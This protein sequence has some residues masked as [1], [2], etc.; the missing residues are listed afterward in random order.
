MKTNR[1]EYQPKTGAACSC[2][3]GQE[4]D[5][6]AKCEGTGR[7]IDF[8]A[9]RARTTESAAAKLNAAIIENGDDTE[10]ED[11][12]RVRALC[13]LL[14]CEPAGLT[15][16]YRPELYR[17]QVRKVKR[18]TSPA[19][20]AKLADLLARTIAGLEVLAPRS[21]GLDAII[22]PAATVDTHTCVMIPPVCS[23]ETVRAVGY[24]AISEAIKKHRPASLK[25]GTHDVLN[26]LYFLSR[27]T[28]GEKEH[29]HD[30]RDTLR[31]AW[32]A[33]YDKAQTVT[34]RRTTEETDSG[35]YLVLTDT[36]ADKAQDE[37]LESL[38]DDTG[39]VPGSDSPYFDRERWK[40]DARQDGRG[41]IISG[42]DGEEREETDPATGETFYIY[43]TN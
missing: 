37:A 4:R 20:A 35:H 34:D 41:H 17:L 14:D 12:A 16:G 33:R 10:T 24:D 18:G 22:P 26:S 7:V 31:E 6:C 43:R 40:T 25:V 28:D 2:R 38:L 39:C 3:K 36:E 21:A 5:N 11:A 27:E 23:L 13:V 15:Q 29:A 1:K 30:H 32:R 42:Y 19:E 8:A 9:I